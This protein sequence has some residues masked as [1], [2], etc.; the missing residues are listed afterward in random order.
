MLKDNSIKLKEQYDKKRRKSPEFVIGD[1]VMLE[2]E[3]SGEKSKLRIRRRGPYEVVKVLDKDRCVI[4]D[5][6]GEKQSLREYSGIIS[7]DK[8][9]LVPKARSD[10]EYY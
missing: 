7:V 3:P 4:K 2:M 6:E 5:I 10:F 1:L 8:L 9:K